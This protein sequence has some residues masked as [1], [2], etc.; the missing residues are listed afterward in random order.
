MS[1]TGLGVSICVTAAVAL[2]ALAADGS[3]ISFDAIAS[4]VVFDDASGR[5]V[6]F[7]SA[8][9]RPV[10]GEFI[11]VYPVLSSL[12]DKEGRE[13]DDRAVSS[14]TNAWERCYRCVNPK[15]PGLE[16]IKT[17]RPC[18]GGIRRTVEFVRVDSV[19]NTVYVQLSTECRFNPDFK[20][21]AW[22]FGAGYLGPIK[23]FP[24]DGQTRPVNEYR[25]S[26]KGLVFTHPN[27]NAGSFA[28]FR[29]HINGMTVFPWWHS[30]IGHY[31]EYGD[32]LWYM[33]GGYRMCLGTLDVRPGKSA[34]Y[35]DQFTF[36]DGNFYA[37]F[38]DVFAKDPDFSAELKS[39][40]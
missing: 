28:H 13:T 34:S 24:Q 1:R 21:D 27:G 33:K 30:T 14:R 25:Q 38:D 36:F 12:G 2:S 16:I 39:V 29:T 4:R 31:R 35:T 5:I 19:T 6:G 15:L 10:A 17:Y 11:N 26:S 22:H 40:R 23:P 18:N 20:K 9:G 37:F 3:R 7:S 32:R 8:D